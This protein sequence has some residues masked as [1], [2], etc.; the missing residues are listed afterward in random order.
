MYF[1]ES[2]KCAICNKLENEKADL[3]VN[4]FWICP[5]CCSNLRDIIVPTQS[6]ADKLADM[7]PEKPI[8]GRM[9]SV[10]E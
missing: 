10:H 5:E 2:R 6:P 3:L 4:K 7:R 8:P 1:N 9:I